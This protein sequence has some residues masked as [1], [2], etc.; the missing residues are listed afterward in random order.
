[1][2]G[3]G[4][5]SLD[6][7]FKRLFLLTV[8]FTL[9]GAFFEFNAWR[10][11]GER[12][13]VRTYG[14]SQR[15]LLAAQWLK[16]NNGRR[17]EAFTEFS[18]VSSAYIRFVLEDAGL[19]IGAGQTV[20]LI[21]DERIYAFQHA[22]GKRIHIQPPQGEGAWLLFPEGRAVEELRKLD[23]SLK[24][25]WGKLTDPGRAS[26]AE[27]AWKLY[28]ASDKEEPYL[29]S[30]LLERAW[31]D[32]VILHAIPQ[33]LMREALKGSFPNPRL[34]EELADKVL[35]VAPQTSFKLCQRALRIDPG[36]SEA[37]RLLEL[38]RQRLA[39]LNL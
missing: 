15:W 20:A 17:L 5:A 3:L 13:A 23:Q 10:N 7:N 12:Y 38:A 11:S 8:G 14:W 16:N 35:D 30:M 18:D 19:E 27:L 29:R 1:V 37:R 26:S 2:A 21:P 9:L 32:S 31:S 4:A 34:D 28:L 24:G 33:D 6:I 22:A 36:S 25:I 39:K